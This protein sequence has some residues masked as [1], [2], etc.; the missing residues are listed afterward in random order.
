MSQLDLAKTHS[1][2]GSNPTRPPGLTTIIMSVKVIADF[3]I[4]TF[5]DIVQDLFSVTSLLS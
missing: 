2:Q 5:L 4:F 3:I 1:Q